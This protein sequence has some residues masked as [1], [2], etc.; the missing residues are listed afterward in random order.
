MKA[1]PNGEYDVLV[2]ALNGN[3]DLTVAAKSLVDQRQQILEDGLKK[4]AAA[5]LKVSIDCYTY[6]DWDYLKDYATTAR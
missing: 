1:R 6:P 4:E 5:G 2:D 3:K